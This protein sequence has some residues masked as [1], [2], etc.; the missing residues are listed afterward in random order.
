M[1]DCFWLNNDGSKRQ[2]DIQQ[3]QTWA[4]FLEKIDSVHGIGEEIDVT[5][6]I[7]VI[8]ISALNS[9]N[10][11]NPNKLYYNVDVQSLK[12]LLKFILK[13]NPP[14][15][16]IINDADKHPDI[17]AAYAFIQDYIMSGKNNNVLFEINFGTETG[18][19]RSHILDVCMVERAT[20]LECKYSICQFMNIDGI[21]YTETIY[22]GTK[23]KCNEI[24]QKICDF[25]YEYATFLDLLK[26][27][28]I[29]RYGRQKNT[30]V[31]ER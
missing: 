28:N 16:I 21:N 29:G 5:E 3:F 31:Q 9:E 23:K 18:S 14:D 24:W 22:E 13:D 19:Q 11:N 30:G 27:N 7:A 12:R 4:D 17:L 26:A 1:D 6:K 15:R 8:G 20:T 2:I 10:N 25:Q